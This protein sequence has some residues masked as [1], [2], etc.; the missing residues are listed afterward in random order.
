MLFG[1]YIWLM[2]LVEYFVD[3]IREVFFDFFDLEVCVYVVF[4]QMV[5]GGFFEQVDVIF[6]CVEVEGK[7]V[8]K[9]VIKGV[10]YILQMDLLLGE[11]I[12]EL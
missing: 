5:I 7:F 8:C 9:F 12:V 4:I 1:E 3:E 6:V 10:S 2:V 11:F